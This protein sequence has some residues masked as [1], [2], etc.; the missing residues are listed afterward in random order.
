MAALNIVGDTLIETAEFNEKL[1]NGDISELITAAGENRELAVNFRRG[2]VKSK[3]FPSAAPVA[4]SFNPIGIGRPLSIEIL[5]IYTGD[6]IRGLFAGKKRDILCVSGAR[7]LN[8]FNGIPRAINIVDRARDKTYIEFNALK[9][10]TPFIYYTKAADFDSLSIS[11][12]LDGRSFNDSIFSTI[13][14]LMR[15]AAGLPIF[16]PAAGFLLGGSEL[17]KLAASAGKEVF[18]SGAFISET[19]QINFAIAGLPGSVSRS[20]LLCRDAD[21]E[22]LRQYKIDYTEHGGSYKMRLMTGNHEYSGNAPY[23]IINIDGSE[24]SFLESFTPTLASSD[25]LSRFYGSE[26][27]MQSAGAILQDAMQ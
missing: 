27:T 1:M 7:P 21:S 12:E 23:I 18:E 17:V 14:G 22:E 10:G 2:T 15:K 11:V 26:D 5:T 4:F 24:R 20:Y 8:A 9:S 3:S 13:S 6:F 16:L 25:L 19:L